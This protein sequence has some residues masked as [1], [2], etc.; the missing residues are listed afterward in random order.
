M[1]K[2]GISA[3]SVQP[4]ALSSANPLNKGRP[5]LVFAWRQVWQEAWVAN[6]AEAGAAW[7]GGGQ[8]AWLG[9]GSAGCLAFEGGKKGSKGPIFRD[10][11]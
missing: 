2:W 11:L 7:A 1:P 5:G 9:L 4:A 6:M 3:F 8:K 10:F